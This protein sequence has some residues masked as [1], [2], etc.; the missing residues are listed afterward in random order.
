MVYEANIA[1][2]RLP[3]AQSGSKNSY[4]D[5]QGRAVNSPT[6]GIYINNGRKA[7]VK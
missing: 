1:S 2:I 6:K 3:K 7:I 4:Y 5:L